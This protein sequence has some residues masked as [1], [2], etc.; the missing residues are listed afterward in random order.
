MRHLIITARPSSG[1]EGLRNLAPGNARGSGVLLLFCTPEGCRN[2][3]DNP[4]R[5]RHTLST[6]HLSHSLFTLLLLCLFLPT[7]SA[8][9]SVRTLAGAPL[10]SAF[11]DGPG[12]AAR[13]AD[14]VGLALDSVGNVFIADSANHCLRQLT[15]AGNV[16]TIAGRAG[17]YGSNDGG[18]GI[19]RFDTPSA[20]AVAR[21]G[22]LFIS[23]TG[24]NT[25]RRRAANGTVSTFAGFAGTPGSTN[26]VGPVAR[27]N[28]PLGLALAANGDLFVADSGNHVIRRISSGGSVT[29]FAG[30]AELW[31]AADGKGDQA[32]FN[33]P[34]GLVFDR[35]GNLLVADS[36]N[37]AIRKITP[38][39][40]VTTLAG[41]LG[42]DGYADGAAGDARFGAPAELAFDPN[43]NLFVTDG[44]YDTLRKI[45][46]NGTVSTVAGLV[47]TEGSADGSYG[48]ARFFNPYGLVA[49]PTG[50]LIVS[51]TYNELI[52]E[53]ITPFTLSAKRTANSPTV[54]HWESIAG[55]TYRVLVRD[56]LSTP[57][58]PL[59]A[60]LTA[61]G[62]AAEAT[63]PA[64]ANARFYQVER[65][66]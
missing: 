34:V 25:I 7:L 27:F 54:I 40:T 16:T 1:P 15:P 55:R 50:S 66:D 30:G 39:G 60:D 31:G 35:A 13:F 5:P 65:I 41:K 53:V 42:E 63:D 36:F 8:A 23:D 24:N 43:G 59:G 47:G 19:A 52:R 14:P 64:A 20:L 48:G 9:D 51:D 17:D 22:T 56:S 10:T 61:T 38:D 58:Q 6:Y 28:A 29:T 4:T 45:T 2:R 37:H 44:W 46:P 18:L 32:R 49:T 62:A 12:G 11:A 21:D 57:W 3:P 26:G 33:G